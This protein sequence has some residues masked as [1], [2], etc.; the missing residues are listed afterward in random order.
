MAREAW[1]KATAKVKKARRARKESCK[2]QERAKVAWNKARKESKKVQENARVAWEK[3]KGKKIRGLKPGQKS[4]GS[5]WKGSRRRTGLLAK[6]SWASKK[7]R[8]NFHQ[9]STKLPPNYG[10]NS[11]NCVQKLTCLCQ[12]TWRT[13]NIFCQ[14]PEKTCDIAI[15]FLIKS[16]IC[17]W[18][19]GLCYLENF[20]CDLDR[21]D[22]FHQNSWHLRKTKRQSLQP[23]TVAQHRAMTNVAAN[24]LLWG[25]VAGR[26]AKI[27]WVLASHQNWWQES[28]L[29]I[30][31]FST[32]YLDKSC[33]CMLLRFSDSYYLN[34]MARLSKKYKCMMIQDFNLCWG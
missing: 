4:A 6:I 21:V 27:L 17:R 32:C 16:S 23:Q 18:Y 25:L 1:K 8:Q 14:S 9:T 7:P 34:K 22:T 12:K 24:I 13:F 15:T 29:E 2:A 11:W 28:Y 30:L 26:S 20:R 33:G 3:A 31:F 5:S 10:G 19:L